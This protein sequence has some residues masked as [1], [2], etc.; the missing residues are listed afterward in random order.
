MG[1][2]SVTIQANIGSAAGVQGL[3]QKIFRSARR[4][5]HTGQQCRRGKACLVLG[6]HRI[7]LRSRAQHESQRSI[8]RDTGICETSH[9]SEATRQSDQFQFSPRRTAIPSLY[10][11]LR[12]QGR[13][14]MMMRSLHWHSDWELR[15]AGKSADRSKNPNQ[16][17]INSNPKLQHNQQRVCAC[18]AALS[19]VDQPA[20]GR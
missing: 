12:Q 1:R 14:K 19:D 3:I 4:A 11:L 13:R 18:E 15:A 6:S 16:R 20:L 2:R 17:R 7:R 5:P 9:T 8:F 10:L